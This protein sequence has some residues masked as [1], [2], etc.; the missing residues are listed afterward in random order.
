MGFVSGCLTDYLLL[1]LMERIWMSDT[2]PLVVVVTDGE[3]LWMPYT[4][5]MVVTDGEFLWV[6]DTFP[7]SYHRCRV[8][9]DA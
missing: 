3:C 9:V 2:L 6:P 1:L 4:L 7:D 8:S 5:S